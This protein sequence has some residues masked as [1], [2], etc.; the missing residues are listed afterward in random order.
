MNIL[1]K[2]RRLEAEV[3]R[4]VERQARHWSNSGD[5][6]P[7]EIVDA[8]VETVAE[9]LEP[10][11]RGRYVFPFNRVHVVIAAGSRDARARFAAILE[12]PPTLPE[13]LAARLHD[14]GCAASAIDVAVTYVAAPEEAWGG[15]EFRVECTRARTPPAAPPAAPAP[16]IRAIT[17]AILSGTAER[18]SYTFTIPRVNLGRCTEVRDSLGRPIRT[19]QVSFSDESG[20][21][22][23]TVSRQ[24]A[25]LEYVAGAGHYRIRDD[26][27]AHGTGVVRNGRMI[28][29]PAGSRGIRLESGDEIVLGEARARVR[30]GR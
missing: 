15:R 26:R 23:Q 28:P 5:R 1:Q 4:A 20:A 18:P 17:I 16:A 14:A 7:L 30:I 27:S 11:P 24:H 12:T 3:T 29:V 8:I 13:R 22:N 9:R 10:A 25:H 19:N 6:E 21:T 2:V